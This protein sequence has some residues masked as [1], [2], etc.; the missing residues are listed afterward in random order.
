MPE[1]PR[2][3]LMLIC[4]ENV[5][6]GQTGYARVPFAAVSRWKSDH[7]DLRVVHGF[8]M[9]F[10]LSS[11]DRALERNFLAM[12]DQYGVPADWLGADFSDGQGTRLR[13]LGIEP[14]NRKYKFVMSNLDTMSRHKVTLQYLQRLAKI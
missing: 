10:D 11:R 1:Y 14:S 9:A 7:P 12:H 2:N 13:L 5:S 3:A 8:D 4:Y 6:T